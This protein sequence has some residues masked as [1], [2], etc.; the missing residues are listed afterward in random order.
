[1]ALTVKRV[2]RLMAKGR[3]GMYRDE[4]GLYLAIQNKR[5]ASWG[6]RYQL[7]HKPRFMGLGSAFTFT[8]EQARQRAKAARELLADGIDPLDHRRSETAARKAAVASKLT[9]KEACEKFIAQRDVEWTSAKHAAEYL[10]SLKR[11]AW[12]YLGSMDVAEIGVPHVLSVL[13][14]KVAAEKGYP[15]G[16][17][18]TARM[19]TADRTRNRVENVLS[20]CAARGH[21]PKDLPN[22][23][24]WSGNL[25]HVLASPA[26]AVRRVHHAAV[27][28][29]ELPSLMGELAKRDGVGVKGLMFTIMTAARAGET[30]GATWE[31]IDFANKTWTIPA[32]RMKGRREHRVPLA[33]QVIALLNGLYREDG[34]PHLFIG[35][36]NA[37]LGHMAM[38]ATLERLG[39][40]E[41]V[42]GMRSAFSDWAHERT[43]HSNHTIE[44]CLAHNI[45][46][47]VEKAYRRT[48]LFAK[49]RALMEQ[50][51]TF[52]T[53]LPK[54]ASG[55]KVVALRKGA[56]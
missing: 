46:S 27:P 25:E 4:R 50:W 17:F 16:T 15:A 37:Q 35:A 40:C 36:R 1:M 21:R 18:W 56:P 9:F 38:Y 11:Y 47:E 33:P 43:A 48:D 52:V 8:L 34:N 24:A 28:Y 55:G 20:W 23:A 44:L 19:T 26:K 32:A 30:L 53:T 12:P 51:A 5:A 31:E 6:L 45:G 14:Q 10:S 29:A 7:D 3:P 41:T 49:R 39:R 13:E 54:A 42:H 2:A 22:P